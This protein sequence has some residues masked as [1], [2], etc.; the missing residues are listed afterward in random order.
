MVLDLGLQRSVKGSRIYA[1][2]KGVVDAGININCNKKVF[3][4]EERI[5]GLH[6]KRKDI[7]KKFEEIKNKIEN[8]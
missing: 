8:G 5:K 3:P 1:A 4:N 2:L 6:T 7:E